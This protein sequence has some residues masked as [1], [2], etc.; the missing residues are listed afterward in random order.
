MG[1]RYIILV[2]GTLKMKKSIFKGCD[3][4][5]CKTALLRVINAIYIIIVIYTY[6]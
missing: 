3:I 1:S 6:F 4:I 2:I 5:C